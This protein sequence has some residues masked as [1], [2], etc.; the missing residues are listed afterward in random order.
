MN[1][2]NIECDYCKKNFNKDVNQFNRNSKKDRKNFCSFSCSAKFNGS[3]RKRELEK[4]H[5][6]YLLDP[7]KCKVCD[8]AIEYKYRNIK[9]FC[10][11]SCASVFNNK[12]RIRISK[13]DQKKCLNCGKKNIKNKFCSNSCSNTHK[14]NESK[15]EA[16]QKI[17]SGNFSCTNPKRLKQFISDEKGHKCQMCGLTEWGGKPILLILD[18]IDGNSENINLDNLRL[19]CSN[20]DTLTPTYKGRNRGN[21]RFLRRERYNQ[22]KSF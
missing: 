19:I 10:S 15:N 3:I 5:E 12:I 22:N 1:T 9:K 8:I 20:C 6:E 4:K 17:K 16:F 18:H 2:I 14:A 21:G 11:Q 7:I 13:N